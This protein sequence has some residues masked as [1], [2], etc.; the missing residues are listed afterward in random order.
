MQEQDVN[1]LRD[2]FAGFLSGKFFGST[3]KCLLMAGVFKAAACKRTIFRS[4]VVPLGKGTL[5]A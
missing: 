3:V 2:Y 1:E 5:V 4:F